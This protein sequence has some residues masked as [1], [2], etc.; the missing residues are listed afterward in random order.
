MN[1]VTAHNATAMPL[2]EIDG[3]PYVEAEWLQQRI[4]RNEVRAKRWRQEAGRTENNPQ[5]HAAYLWQA[6]Q[7]TY[8]AQKWKK[9]L[10]QTLTA[11]ARHQHTVRVE[12]GL[13]VYD[14]RR[15]AGMTLRDLASRAG[16]DHKTILNIEKARFVPTMRILRSVV[17]V[18]ELLLT[19]AEVKPELLQLNRADER[20]HQKPRRVKG[21]RSKQSRRR[22]PEK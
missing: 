13:L 10:A 14:R 22:A 7:A 2:V 19:W 17:A 18:R 8:R 1:A 16:V 21:R 4:Y 6:L 5:L 9:C 15:A 3:S 12:F 11:I 20:K